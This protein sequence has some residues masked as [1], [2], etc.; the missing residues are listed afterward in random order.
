MASEPAIDSLNE[1]PAPSHGVIEPVQTWF[2]TTLSHQAFVLL[3]SAFCFFE[4]IFLWLYS[5][6]AWFST[7]LILWTLPVSVFT[8]SV[9]SFCLVWLETPAGCRLTGFIS[10]G[11]PLAPFRRWIL[12]N[13]RGFEPS[14]R[15]GNR[16]ALWSAIDRAELTFFGNLRLLSR[17]ASGAAVMQNVRGR[18]RDLNPPQL[19]FKI[20]FG[21]ASRKDQA[22][23]VETLRQQNPACELNSRLLKQLKS[24]D[25]RG[26]T[27]VLNIVSLF[28]LLFYVDVIFSTFSYLEILKNYTIAKETGES[29]TSSEIMA[30][31]YFDLA[32]NI[33]NHPLPISWVT[34]KIFQTD[35]ARS[36][37]MQ[38]R[39]DALWSMNKRGAAIASMRDA[40][41]VH[42][43]NFR[44]ELKLARM[45]VA[46]N[47]TKEAYEV[48]DK[49]GAKS[50]KAFV[51][52][53]YVLALL[54]QE[55]SPGGE[56]AQHFYDRAM[57]SLDDELFKDVTGWPPGVSPYLPDVW[58]REDIDFVFE[59]MLHRLSVPGKR[60]S[61]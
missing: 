31:K 43:K 14:I 24:D 29:S 1:L 23:F 45:L 49:A 6:R 42:G 26:S 37:V 4:L 57:K 17:A 55:N 44:A 39:A 19:I 58:H 34:R 13:E 50:K 35:S 5:D 8:I 15:F 27:I 52:K 60:N 36:G 53:M 11:S 30:E 12:L 22:S 25:P 21:I 10:K 41:E 20:P 54:H 61:I 38:V 56:S 3:S 2:S 32:E 47:Q 16:R 33:R 46:M 59:R 7:D 9:V 48:L 51:P 40:L 18:Q 28:F